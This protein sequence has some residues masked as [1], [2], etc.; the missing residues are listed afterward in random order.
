M[1]IVLAEKKDTEITSEAKRL[2][3]TVGSKSIEA[4]QKVA[5]PDLTTVEKQR[6]KAFHQVAMIHTLWEVPK[7]PL[8]VLHLLS[9]QMSPC[10]TF[11]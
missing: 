4:P 2:K 9:L 3:S 8:I 7:V 1:A 5:S 10:F 6:D 11:R